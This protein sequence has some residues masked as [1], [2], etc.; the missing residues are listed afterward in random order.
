MKRHFTIQSVATP[1]SVFGN[2]RSLE[3]ELPPGSRVRPDHTRG[4]HVSLASPSFALEYKRSYRDLLGPV[5]KGTVTGTH[6]GSTI[7]A[8]IRPGR[9]LLILPAMWIAVLAY[10]WM[11]RGSLDL[12]GALLIL[13]A[14]IGLGV[15]A[16]LV[17][18]FSVVNHEAEA[19]GLE[20]LVRYAARNAT[21]AVA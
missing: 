17:T 18:S 14:C 21:S 8:V 2:L 1:Q 7:T 3:S 16:M 13:A 9:S 12:G 10:G 6:Q 15:V 4:L 5:C 20:A 19:D 11:R